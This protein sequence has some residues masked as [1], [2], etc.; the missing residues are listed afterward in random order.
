MENMEECPLSAEK[1]MPKHYI[2]FLRYSVALRESV[3]F[4]KNPCQTSPIP[5][6]IYMMGCLTTLQGLITDNTNVLA[7]AGI[8]V[9]SLM[10][11]FV[12]HSTEY[13]LC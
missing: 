11:N 4:Q 6:N 1:I 10:V 13:C 5:G 12:V 9:S 3:W 8:G 2:L 7:G